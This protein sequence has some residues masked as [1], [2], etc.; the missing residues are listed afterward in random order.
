MGLTLNLIMTHKFSEVL[1]IN[2]GVNNI[3]L[4]FFVSFQFIICNQF[5]INIFGRLLNSGKLVLHQQT[6]FDVWVVSE[7]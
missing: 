7:V 2:A 6:I 3:L 1:L 5:C 4:I